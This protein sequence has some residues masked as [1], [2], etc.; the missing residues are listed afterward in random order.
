VG[1]SRDMEF[2]KTL[3]MGM[4]LQGGPVGDPGVGLLPWSL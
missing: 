2:M 1:T 4:S 3:G